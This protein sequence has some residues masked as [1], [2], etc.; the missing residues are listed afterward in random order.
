MNKNTDQTSGEDTSIRLNRFLAQCGLGARRK[1]DELIA[2]GHVLVNGA[3]VVQL[4]SK[5]NP[6]KDI[7]EHAGKQLRPIKKLEYLAM[8]KPRCVMTTKED[9][10]GRRTV[11]DILNSPDIDRSHLNYIG[12]LDYL[13]DGLLLFTNDGDLVHA[14]THPRFHIKKVYRVKTARSL[15]NKEMDI[16]FSGIE[17]DGQLLHAG[18]I[19]RIP[20]DQ[21]NESPW[22]E[23]DLFEGKNRQIRRMFD[24]VGC[25]IERL[26]RIQFG[27]VKLGDLKTGEVR[28]LSEREVDALRNSGYKK[29]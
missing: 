29:S 20:A 9:P 2:A 17:S 4:G 11:Y 5:I 7:V 8:N 21:A 3:K 10:E 23:I 13:S 16:F 1:C 15:T 6:E 19:R 14:L 26:I 27:S 12:R 25:D 18:A 28:N 22:Y 24:A